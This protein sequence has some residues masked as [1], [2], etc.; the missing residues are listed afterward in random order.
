[1]STRLI[2][3]LEQALSVRADS[4]SRFGR[5]N[6]FEDDFG[7]LAAIV[8]ILRNSVR[9]RALVLRQFSI[10]SRQGLDAVVFW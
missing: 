1:M 3:L 8:P 10:A 7:R 6:D 5:V 2:S 4:P 9:H